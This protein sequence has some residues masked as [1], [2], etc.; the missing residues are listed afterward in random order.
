[1]KKPTMKRMKEATK[2]KGSIHK[3][4]NLASTLPELASETTTN[5]PSSPLSVVR[6]CVVVASLRYCAV[7]GAIASRARRK[8]GTRGVGLSIK[9]TCKSLSE[10]TVLPR[11]HHG[12][13]AMPRDCGSELGGLGSSKRGDWHEGMLREYVR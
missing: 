1:M 2:A 12:T 7:V 6:E 4:R 5:P 8:P 3:P 13:E 9:H 11:S 10:F